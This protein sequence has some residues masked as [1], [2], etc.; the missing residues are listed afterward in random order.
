MKDDGF[1]RDAVREALE[2]LPHTAS[3]DLGRP[4][5]DTGQAMD[6]DVAVLKQRAD[7]HDRRMGRVEDKI[8]RLQDGIN[9]IKLSLGK[10]PTKGTLWAI[11]ATGATVGLTILAIVLAVQGNLQSAFQAG[12]SVVQ[13]HAALPGTPK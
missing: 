7:E 5:A 9:D 13:T 12:L 8:D 4:R 2:S 3:V 1:I 11:F 6:P 10:L